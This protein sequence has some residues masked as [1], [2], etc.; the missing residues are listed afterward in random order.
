MHWAPPQIQW[1]APPLTADASSPTQSRKS[2]I[3][4]FFVQQQLGYFCFSLQDK[5][6]TR[7]K[8][9]WFPN[10]W[11]EAAELV[12]V[13]V[14]LRT[15]VLLWLACGGTCNFTM[16]TYVAYLQSVTFMHC[17][18][19]WKICRLVRRKHCFRLYMYIW[20]KSV[21][22]ACHL[23]VYPQSLFKRSVKKKKWRQNAF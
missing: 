21:S 15:G 8:N 12:E 16:Q 23:K 2:S 18:A 5:K 20:K 19:P 14:F 6:K 9:N 7:K 22:H 1:V 10:N 3:V 17:I 13:V 11:E 4:S